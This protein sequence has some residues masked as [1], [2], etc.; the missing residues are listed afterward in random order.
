MGCAFKI[1]HFSDLTVYTLY[2]MHQ[3]RTTLIELHRG[4]RGGCEAALGFFQHLIQNDGAWTTDSK[5]FGRM[6]GLFCAECLSEIGVSK[7]PVNPNH[8]IKP[9]NGE[10]KSSVTSLLESTPPDQELPSGVQLADRISK[11]VIKFFTTVPIEDWD[12][13]SPQEV[14]T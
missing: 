4:A 11:R 14:L 13:E 8:E 7:A 5:N 6:L 10:G 12:K 3:D 1:F 9:Q 2:R